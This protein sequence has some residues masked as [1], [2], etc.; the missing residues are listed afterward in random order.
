MNDATPASTS[1]EMKNISKITSSVVA[2]VIGDDL[3]ENLH[4]DRSSLER[5]MNFSD[6]DDIIMFYINLHTFQDALFIGYKQ[7]PDNAHSIA[8]SQRISS[9]N[10]IQDETFN[11]RDIINKLIDY[12]EG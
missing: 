11:D 3:I 7:S 4:C 5:Y 12:E 2:N 10:L 1:S 8:F 9:T 6:F